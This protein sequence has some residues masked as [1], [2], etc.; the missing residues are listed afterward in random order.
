MALGGALLT[1]GL[2][3]HWGEVFPSWLPVLAGRRVPP[4]LAIVPATVASVVLTT[5]G[6]TIW[7]MVIAEGIGAAAGLGGLAPGLAF[8][9]WGLTLGL[10]TLAYYYRRRGRCQYCGRG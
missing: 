5:G 3:Q 2:I 6:L 10:A 9:P 1:L 7:R 8:L 4:G